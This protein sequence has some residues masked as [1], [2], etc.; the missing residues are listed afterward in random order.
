[1][2]HF[3]TVVAPSQKPVSMNQKLNWEEAIASA[4]SV[5]YW[6]RKAMYD[7][8]KRSFTLSYERPNPRQKEA[9]SV[10][11]TSSLWMSAA[12]PNLRLNKVG[13]GVKKI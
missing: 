13:T 5:F 3:Q 10:D 6:S 7:P 2:L 12:V 9:A 1:M 11:P 4:D 8:K